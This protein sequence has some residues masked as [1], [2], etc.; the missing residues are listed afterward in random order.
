MMAAFA[1]Y[2]FPKAHAASYAQVGWRSAWC[3]EYFPAE[4]MAAVLANW[5]GYYSQRVY[6]SE[7]RRLGL[8]VRPPHVNYSQHN[9][10]VRRLADS[11]EQ[12]LFMGLDQVKELTHRTIGRI[13][14]LAPFTSLDD[15]LTR[16]DPRVQEAESLTRVGAMDGLGRIPAILKRLQDG[17]WQKN[18]MSLFG[19]NDTSE[20]DWT[21]QQKVAA[22]TEILGTGLNAHPL[23]LVAEKITGASSTLEAVEKIGRR[24][25][26][27]GIR[28]TSRRSRTAKGEIMLF[29]TLEDLHGTLDIILF[30]AVY[31]MAKAM[32]DSN[33]PFLITGIMEVD[34]ERGEPYLKAEKLISVN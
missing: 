18:Q 12:A 27:A 11:A 16:V 15:F 6:L 34:T 25:T 32:L 13:I 29:L 20:E 5:G 1:G 22:Q 4:F 30:P 17:G 3:K 19:W 9:F 24:V 8:K 26:V 10:T 2:G 14:Q 7:A 28:Q 21:L 31:R 33:T 23:E